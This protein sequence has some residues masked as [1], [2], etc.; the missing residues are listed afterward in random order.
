ML[1]RLED[2]W[3]VSLGAIFG[4]NTR[5]IIYRKLEKINLNKDTIILII[6]TLASFFLGLFLSNLS[7]LSSL[8]LFDQLILFLVIGFFGSLST[9]STFV[10]DIYSLFLKFDFLR[11]L[12]LFIISLLLGLI[13]LA[14]GFLLGN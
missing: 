8:K 2:I 3:L 7:R 12:K 1:D 4:A 9:F 14:F 5:F 6:N 10:F 13:S 11:A